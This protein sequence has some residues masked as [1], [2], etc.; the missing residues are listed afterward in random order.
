[1]K[2]DSNTIKVFLTRFAPAKRYTK[3]DFVDPYRDWFWAL[4]FSF[5]C[6]V[7]GVTYIAADFYMQFEIVPE[8]SSENSGSTTYKKSDVVLYANIYKEKE[9]TFNLLRANQPIPEIEVVPATTT[10]EVLAED[11]VSQ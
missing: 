6:L 5:C 7:V 8:Y 3:R 1:M 2:L 11:L 9:N 10:E 4:L